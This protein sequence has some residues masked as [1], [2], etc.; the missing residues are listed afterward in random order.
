MGVE[1][2]TNHISFSMPNRPH[3][4]SQEWRDLTLLHWIVEPEKLAPYIPEGLELDLYKGKAY[5]SVVPFMM[6]N[7]RPRW[8]PAVPGVSTFPEFNIRTY[9][10]KNGKAGVFFLTLEAQSNITCTYAPRAYGLPYN[11]A[12]AKFTSG[13]GVYIWKSKR[14]R[15][16]IGIDGLARATGEKKKAK[17]GTL[18]YF[19]FERYCLYVEHKDVL[20]IAHTLHDPW[21]FQTADAIIKRNSLTTAYN[22]GIE[23]VYTPDIAHVSEG[24]YVHTWPIEL[25]ERVRNPD[26]DRDYLFLDGD[27]GLCHRLATFIDKRLSGKQE[28][29]Y[30]PIMDEDAQRII[31]TMPEKYQKADTVYLIRNGRPY[32]RSAAGIRGLLYMKWYYKMWYPLLWAVP[33]PLRDVVYKLIAKYRHK[34]F[35]KPKVCTFRVD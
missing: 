10:T 20:Y 18:D 29:G 7:V 17:S 32:I 22:L 1:I 4:L 8:F 30:R 14:P 28:L 31:A 33:L 27:C 34:V 15:T 25:V 3:A 26:D 16:D 13:K 21:E 9:V 24:V 6:K 12:R 2:Q 5:I 35:D 19:L 23:D 11:Y